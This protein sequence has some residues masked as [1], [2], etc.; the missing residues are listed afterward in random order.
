MGD[1]KKWRVRNKEIRREIGREKEREET[2]IK[3]EKRTLICSR[4]VDA[5]PFFADPDPAQKTL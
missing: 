3:I 1:R 5:H 4:A 2:E